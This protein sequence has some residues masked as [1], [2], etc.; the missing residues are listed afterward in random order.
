MSDGQNILALFTDEL[1]QIISG[2]LKLHFTNRVE[3][4]IF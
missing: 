2:I 3:I 4:L 1:G